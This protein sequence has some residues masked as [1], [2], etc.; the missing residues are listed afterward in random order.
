MYIK[1]I[2]I[3][4]LWLIE[5]LH[6][7]KYKMTLCPP[8][9]Q[10]GK[11]WV[12][13]GRGVGS[14]LPSSLPLLRP[15]A[16][17]PALPPAPPTP[18]A[19]APAPTTPNLCLFLL[20][21]RVSASSLPLFSVKISSRFL[22]PGAQHLKAQ[23]LPVPGALVST[24]D[25]PGRQCSSIRAADWLGRERSFHVLHARERPHPQLKLSCTWQ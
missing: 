24:A 8:S 1:C 25:W 21:S 20:S 10:Q 19:F 11:Q 23:P 16:F 13:G 17:L 5:I 22:H 2:W 4:K 3:V 7:L 6:L 18:T 12:V 14:P 9:L 15:V